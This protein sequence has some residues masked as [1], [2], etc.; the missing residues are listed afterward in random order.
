MALVGRCITVSNWRVS[1]VRVQKSAHG[2]TEIWVGRILLKFYGLV[3]PKKPD[4]HCKS[5]S[6]AWNLRHFFSVSF[7]QLLIHALEVHGITLQR[8][9]V[10]RFQFWSETWL[11]SFYQK[12]NS[13]WLKVQQPKLLIHVE[14]SRWKLWRTL[15]IYPS[16][17]QSRCKQ[18]PKSSTGTSGSLIRGRGLHPSIGTYL[19]GGAS[20]ERCCLYCCCGFSSFPDDSST[21]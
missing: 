12:S 2:W 20:I 11:I 3:P 9:S 18:F 1:F 10:N 6:H 8:N 5:E 21:N 14:W 13:P 4:W 15:D 17:F 7:H 16:T 19:S